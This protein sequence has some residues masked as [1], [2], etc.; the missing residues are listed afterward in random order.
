[1]RWGDNLEY[2]AEAGPG[3]FIHVPPQVSNQEINA[4]ADEPLHCVLARSGQEPV[5]VNLDITGVETPTE[6]RWRDPLHR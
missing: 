2:V 6:V 1:M 4:L 3:A 5:V